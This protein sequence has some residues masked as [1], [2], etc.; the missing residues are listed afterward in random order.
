MRTTRLVQAPTR[1]SADWPGVWDCD[2]ICKLCLG[3]ICSEHADQITNNVGTQLKPAVY[4]LL[5]V[6]SRLG[7]CAPPTAPTS[8]LSIEAR[9][10]QGERTIADPKRGAC[11]P[12]PLLLPPRHPAT[13]AGAT[14]G[15]LDV[16]FQRLC[17]AESFGGAVGTL[18]SLRLLQ[19]RNCQRG[20]RRAPAVATDERRRTVAW[21]SRDRR[22]TAGWDAVDGDRD[23]RRLGDSPCR[24][25]C[26]AGRAVALMRRAAHAKGHGAEGEES[27]RCPGLPSTCPPAPRRRRPSS[28]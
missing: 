18:S 11:S 24:W 1:C 6:V 19:R 8:T 16:G 17:A 20:E 3:V 13:A 4:E 21:P 5:C 7:A 27:R 2:S 22:A 25:P 15:E 12:F 28:R 10:E 23:E 14:L 9:T 26:S